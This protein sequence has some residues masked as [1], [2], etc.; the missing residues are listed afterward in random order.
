MPGAHH[1]ASCVCSQPH[2]TLQKWGE[3]TCP[4]PRWRQKSCGALIPSLTPEPL[5]LVPLTLLSLPHLG[6]RVREGKGPAQGHTGKPQVSHPRSQQAAERLPDLS[7]HGLCSSTHSSAQQNRQKFLP[8]WAEETYD[9]MKTVVCQTVTSAT[10]GNR[11][12]TGDR[13]CV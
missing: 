13:K 3:E 4:R 6:K 10:E 8:S 2:P 12:E 5:F 9:K 11:A 1:L 7:K